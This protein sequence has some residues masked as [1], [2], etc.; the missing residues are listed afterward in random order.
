M[1]AP[2]EHISDPLKLSKEVKSEIMALTDKAMH[3]VKKVLNPEGFNFGANFGKIAGSGI[4][5]HVHY[6]LVP[7]WIGDTNFMPVIGHTKTIVEGLKE[8]YD[9]LKPE[10]NNA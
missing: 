5:D 1:I 6:H 9:S 4:E 7:R 2:Y 10:F 8:T 3:A